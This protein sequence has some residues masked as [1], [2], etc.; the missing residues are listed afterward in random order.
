MTP[1]RSLIFVLACVTLPLT[2]ACDNSGS[3][4]TTP[5]APATVTDTFTGTVQPMS[6]DAH[7]F[8]VAAAGQVGITLT[9]AGPPPTI[10]MGLGIGTV[11]ATDGS[12]VVAASLTA[13]IQASPNPLYA[14]LGAGT[15]CVSVFDVGNQTAPVD[16]TVT[17]Q[18]P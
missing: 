8:T 3:T 7:N 17:V 11:S 14:T 1:T 2:I 16:Y 9:A 4:D 12:C 6:S 15:Y 5:I 18:H 13:T 10:F